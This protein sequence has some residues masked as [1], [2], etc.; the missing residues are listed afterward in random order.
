LATLGAAIRALRTRVGLSQEELA[1]LVGL[2]QG[3][4][5]RMERDRAQMIRPQVLMRLASVLGVS[6]STLLPEATPWRAAPN[7]DGSPAGMFRVGFWESVGTAPVIPVSEELPPSI[8]LSSRVRVG[9]LYKVITPEVQR[10]PRSRPLTPGELLRALRSTYYVAIVVPREILLEHPDELTECAQVA[11][12]IDGVRVAVCMDREDAI[13]DGFDGNVA[14]AGSAPSSSAAWER[15][16]SVSLTSPVRV[17]FPLDG[18]AVGTVH[19]LRDILDRRVELCA[20]A[21]EQWPAFW[22]SAND[23]VAAGGRPAIAVAVEPY[24][25]AWRRAVW[26]SNRGLTTVP[27]SCRA[28]WPDSPPTVSVLSLVFHRERC[29]AWLTKPIVYEFLDAV[30]RQAQEISRHS[31]RVLAAISERLQLDEPA[32]LRECARCD[33]TTRFA[34][35]WVTQLRGHSGGRLG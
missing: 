30:E 5:S 20:I 9:S 29:A 23:A 33:F 12:A 27:V 15:V 8:R 14:L 1:Q 3:E 24:L 31:P 10:D 28:I 34:P 2:S 17:Y 25:D 21:P 26:E 11:L 32:V 16:R 13:A 18:G 4:I 19:R 35:S 6:P 7:D 22:N